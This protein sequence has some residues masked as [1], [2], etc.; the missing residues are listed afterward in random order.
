MSFLFNFYEESLNSLDVTYKYLKQVISYIDYCEFNFYMPTANAKLENWQSLSYY[1]SNK[2]K[3]KPLN[4]EI[5]NSN[6]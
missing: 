4:F 6:P 3:E 5:K 2:I 1:K